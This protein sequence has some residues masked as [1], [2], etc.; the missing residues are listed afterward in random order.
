M[1][2][3]GLLL[4]GASVSRLPPLTQAQFNSVLMRLGLVLGVIKTDAR[5]PVQ[6]RIKQAE[7]FMAK[8]RDA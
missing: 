7:A 1:R 3:K 2:L 6:Q 5:L 4:N 8:A